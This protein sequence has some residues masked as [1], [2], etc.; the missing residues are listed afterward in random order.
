MQKT[1]SSVTLVDLQ[2][3]TKH[4]P[5]K[6]ELFCTYFLSI[7]LKYINISTSFC[8]TG[9]GFHRNEYSQNFA[10]DSN[11]DIVLAVQ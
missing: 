3:T 6:I 1:C 9:V 5:Q 4:I 2:Q 11:I 7:T 8:V 10:C